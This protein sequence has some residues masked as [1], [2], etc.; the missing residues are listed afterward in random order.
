MADPVEPASVAAAEKTA[1]LKWQTLAAP[2]AAVGELVGNLDKVEHF[3]I[4]LLGV[5]PTRYLTTRPA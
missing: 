4:E 2:L 5:T 1:S 3:L